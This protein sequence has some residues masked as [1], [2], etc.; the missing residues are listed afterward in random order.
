MLPN[1]GTDIIWSV[2]LNI[3]EFGPQSNTYHCWF[4]AEDEV[5][6]IIEIN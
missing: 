5:E 4:Y 1:T 2:P 6:H 3:A